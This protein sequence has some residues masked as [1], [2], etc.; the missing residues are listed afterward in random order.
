[1][2]SAMT[3]FIFLSLL[4]A[5]LFAPPALLRKY[6]SRMAWATRYLLSIFPF[7][8]TW[9]GWQTGNVAYD[10]FGCQGGLKN[11][12]ACLSGGIDFTPLVGGC[13]FLMIP[14]AFLASPL[15]L[16]LLFNTAAKH[17]GA[18]HRR[19][20]PADGSKEN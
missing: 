12:H 7:A 5:A 13:L 2:T 20:Y 17:I 11:V 19:N 9:A 4:A 16:W 18:W 1:M 3:N 8:Y 14:C 10:F 15:S 6:E